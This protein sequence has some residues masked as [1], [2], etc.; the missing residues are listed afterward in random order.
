MSAH[1]A[2]GGDGVWSAARRRLTAGLVLTVTLVAFESLAVA[3]IAPEL[4]RDLDGISLYGWM[5]SA[6]FLGSLVGTVAAG[7]TIDRRGPAPAYALGLVLFSGGLLVAGLAPSMAV[8]VLGRAVQ[9]FGAGAIP[10][11]A[12][13]TI[14]RAY[15]EAL[16]PRMFAVMSTA[17]VVPGLAGPALAG[18]V[19]TA[20]SWRAVFLG[21]LPLVAVAGAMALPALRRLARHPA[22]DA[23][24]PGGVDPAGS[25]PAAGPRLLGAV[26]VAV[27]A[28]LLLAGLGVRDWRAAPPLVIAG[29]VL[30]VPA[31]VRLVPPGTV[32][33]AAGLPAAVSARGLLTF[34]FFG[35]DAYVPL[36]FTDVRGTSTAVAGL[37]VTASTISWTAAAWVQDR[38]LVR[39]GAGRLVGVGLATLVMGIGG[40]GSVLIEA[41]PLWVPIAAWMVG[42]FGIG[43]AYSPISFTVLQLAPAGQEGAS[44]ASMQLSD[45]LGVSLG[46]GLGGVA[47]ALADH[48]WDGPRAGIGMAWLG[49]AVLALIG[50][51]V[52]RR[53]P[54]PTRPPPGAVDHLGASPAVSG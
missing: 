23:D 40:V 5:F 52:A 44:T 15:P 38:V 41:V 4:E 31:F 53:L 43:L 7:S 34:A 14:G 3:T 6:F 16:R 45:L 12:Y 1:P 46:T 30:A 13:T 37:A 25:G 49:A 48:V 10:A 20:L 9:G 36:A 29:L 28:V 54:G 35:A 27:G 33:A 51:L 2:P 50:V 19:A 18:L 8:V 17:W 26:R 22:A 47:V 42:G 39:V 21:L 24:V 11:I 32:R